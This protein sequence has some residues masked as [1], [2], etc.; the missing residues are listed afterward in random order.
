MV[1]ETDVD[2]LFEFVKKNKK[3]SL[4]KVARMLNENRKVVEE[5]AKVLEE[6]KLISI[7]YSFNP[8]AKA[9]LRIVED[10]KKQEKGISKK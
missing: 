1:V 8:F 6:S 4:V 3:V 5:W 9:Y 10:G 2:R 7:E